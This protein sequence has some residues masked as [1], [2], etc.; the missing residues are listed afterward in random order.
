MFK[1]RNNTP[2]R[3]WGWGK[4]WVLGEQR[5]LH[6]AS[7]YTNRHHQPFS[8]SFQY[9]T[10][11]LGG[12]LHFTPHWYTALRRQTP[13]PAKAGTQPQVLKD[14]AWIQQ[15]LFYKAYHKLIFAI[16]SLLHG[17]QETTPEER[18]TYFIISKW[19]V[20][21]KE[22]GKIMISKFLAQKES[23]IAALHTK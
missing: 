8:G 15:I 21:S 18:P 22:P 3:R 12:A 17:S 1:V 2:L 13:P 9:S 20:L 16:Y 7:I 19:N 4:N 23:I 5:H 14:P 6:T 10:G 11:L